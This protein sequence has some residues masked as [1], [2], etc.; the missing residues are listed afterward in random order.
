MIRVGKII[1]EMLVKIGGIIEFRIAPDCEAV[2]TLEV[3]DA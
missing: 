2:A 3:E 1:D